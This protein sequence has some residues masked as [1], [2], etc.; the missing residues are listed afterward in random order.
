MKDL[1]RAAVRQGVPGLGVRDLDP[2]AL[3]AWVQADSE[4]SRTVSRS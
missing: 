2:Q 4:E 3:S 1:E